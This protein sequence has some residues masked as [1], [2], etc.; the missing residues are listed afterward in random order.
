[1]Q[2]LRAYKLI[3]GSPGQD[4]KI[5]T[6]IN[7]D[8]TLMPNGIR[9]S[10]DI[11][12]DTTKKTN[13]SKIKIWNLS[14]DSLDLIEKEDL[15]VELWTGYYKENN[16]SRIFLG[17]ALTIETKSENQGKDVVTE[18]KASDGQLAV[19]DSITSIGYPPGTNSGK[20]IKYLAGSMGLSMYAANDVVYPDYPNGFSFCGKSAD[21]LDI[22]CG[23]IGASWSIQNNELQIIM[24]DGTTGIQGLVFNSN[25]GLLDRPE[26][27]VRS[28]YATAAKASARAAKA[29]ITSSKRKTKAKKKINRKQK[30]FGWRFTVLL[31]PT[32]NPGDAVRLE[33]DE[34]NGW[35]KIESLKHTGDN[36][37]KD[38]YT[39]IEG[40]E[41][42]N[43]DE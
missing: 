42:L 3:L 31:S 41:I 18:I 16:L 17:Y 13:K 39:I 24:S 10:F 33:S 8:G 29:E 37:G 43:D 21:A 25:S 4:G 9:I 6:N 30:K 1:M 14:D 20:I 5:I 7:D 15:I 34:F 38:W 32:S 19:R 27:F 26:H 40:I 35:L 2:F 12:K 23:V 22:V 11:D 28:A 36:R